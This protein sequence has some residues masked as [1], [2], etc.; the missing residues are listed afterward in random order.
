MNMNGCFFSVYV[1]EGNN[2]ELI[3]AIVRGI[4]GWRVVEILEVAN[5]VWTQAYRRNLVEK[6]PRQIVRD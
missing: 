1:Q 4:S 2:S 5:F 6:K 3:K